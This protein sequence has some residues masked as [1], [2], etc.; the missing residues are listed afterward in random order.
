MCQIL[1]SLVNRYTYVYC[2]E[3]ERS[4]ALIGMAQYHMMIVYVVVIQ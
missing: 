3:K 2:R 1:V 4:M